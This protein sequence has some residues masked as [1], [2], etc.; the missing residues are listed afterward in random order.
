M[1]FSYV[2]AQRERFRFKKKLRRETQ[3]NHKKF[4]LRISSFDFHLWL[5]SIAQERVEK[6]FGKGAR[7]VFIVSCRLNVALEMTEVTFERITIDVSCKIPF[8]FYGKTFVPRILSFV[9]TF[10]KGENISL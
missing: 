5:A 8:T 10:I 3:I 2:P 4:L 6:N 7:N 1:F 9:K